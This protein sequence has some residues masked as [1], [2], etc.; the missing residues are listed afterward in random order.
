[1]M[2]G[3]RDQGFRQPMPAEKWGVDAVY[4]KRAPS[5]ESQWR[6]FLAAQ[7]ENIRCSENSVDRK[8]TRLNSSHID[9]SRMPSSA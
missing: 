1:M 6:G 2:S 7:L 8:S 5:R 3:E 4:Q 9:R